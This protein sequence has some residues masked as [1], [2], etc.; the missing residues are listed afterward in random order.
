[1]NDQRTDIIR[2][3]SVLA[4]DGKSKR[5]I[6]VD[7]FKSSAIITADFTGT[8]ELVFNQGGIIGSRKIE[9]NPI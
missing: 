4:D 5:K 7:F 3:K 2:R 8:I 1:M 9:N 6:I